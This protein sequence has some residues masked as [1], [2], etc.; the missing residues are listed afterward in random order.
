MKFF[1]IKKKL[2]YTIITIMIITIS[3]IIFYK[4][5]TLPNKIEIEKS[6]LIESFFCLQTKNCILYKTDKE[7]CK[8]NIL[9]RPKTRCEW[10]LII[11]SECDFNCYKH[12]FFNKK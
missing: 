6:N 11:T 2:I 5:K 9:K 7:N 8:N 3:W 4:F 1:K 12:Y 10:N